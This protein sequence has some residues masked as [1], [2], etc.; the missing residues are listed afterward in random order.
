[1]SSI[2]TGRDFARFGLRVHYD[3]SITRLQYIFIILLVERVIVMT[4]SGEMFSSERDESSAKRS[5]GGV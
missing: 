3:G 1:M 4:G 5:D 2:H